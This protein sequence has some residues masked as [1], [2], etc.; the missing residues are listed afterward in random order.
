MG[1]PEAT[2][3]NVQ[4]AVQNLR[5]EQFITD[6]PAGYDTHIDPQGR[7]LPKSIMQKLLLAR[8]I[9]HRPKLLLLEDALE[10]LDEEERSAIVNFLVDKQHNW[11]IVA[12][13]SDPYFQSKAE[14]SR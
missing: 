12:V 1:R 2:F 13:S 7:K 3:A 6:L 11:S 4:W 9:V 10:H 5:L 8:C 14:P